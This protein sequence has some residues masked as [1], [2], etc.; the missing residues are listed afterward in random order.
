MNARSAAT[1]PGSGTASGFAASTSSAVV[2]A[3]PWLMFAPKPSGRV[4]VRRRRRP[5]GTEPGM[6]AITT[7]SSTCGRER[8]QRLRELGRMCRARRRPRRPSRRAPAGRRRPSAVPSPP[9]RTARALEPRAREPLAVV[10]RPRERR[11]E[12]AVLGVDAA[13][14]A[15]LAQRR[16]VGERRPACRS[17]S[18][19]APGCRSPRSA[20]A[21]RAPRRRGRARRAP[22]AS[23]QPRT[24]A[25][26]PRSSRGERR[27]LLG[28]DDDERQPDAP[29]PRRARRAG[30]CAPGSRRRRA[31]SRRAR[32]RPGANAGSTPCGVTVIFVRREAVELDRVA[33]RALRH[34]EH[35]VGAPR[36]A[37]HDRLE[38]R[39]GRASPIT[40]GSR[41]KCRSCS[42]TTLAAAP[43]ERQRVLEVRELAAR[44]G[45]AAAAA[46]TPCAAPASAP[47]ARSARRRPARARAGA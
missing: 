22:P 37:R 28:P 23:T 20:T 5:S 17:P 41:S 9:T 7:S 30:P 2:S 14:P 35:V 29:A 18:P 38:R 8:R 3:T 16:I 31:G 25:P 1:A 40:L 19:R 21:A 11:G 42:V 13:S 4:V 33:L 24:S 32:R 34:G 6:F 36:R 15:D 45:A 43:A 27:L 39:A 12:V 10:E 46:T 26:P 47:A 44:A